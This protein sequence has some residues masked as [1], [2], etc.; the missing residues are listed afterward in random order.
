MRLFLRRGLSIRYLLPD[1][2]IEYIDRNG[3]YLDDATL[4]ANA[5]AA[6]GTGAGVGNGKTVERR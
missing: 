1:G 4:N 6:G 5:N 2:V 3:L